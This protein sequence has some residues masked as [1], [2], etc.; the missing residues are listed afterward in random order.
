M[1]SRQRDLSTSD[2]LA[3]PTNSPTGPGEDDAMWARE[4]RS[5]AIKLAL[6]GYK[7][8]KDSRSGVIFLKGGLAISQ[9]TCLLVLLIL[10]RHRTSPTTPGISQSSVP[11]ESCGKP[12]EKWIIASIVRLAVCWS[13]SIWVVFRR[14]EEG[15]EE[16]EETVE[17]GRSG[18]GRPSIEVDGRQSSST[19]VL[20]T[21]YKDSQT[22]GGREGRSVGNAEGKTIY[23][24]GD[25]EDHRPQPERVVDEP[26]AISS[27]LARGMDRIAPKISLSLGLLSLALFIYGNILLFTSLDTCRRSAPLLWWAVMVVIGVGW[28][29]L[30]EVVLVVLIVGVVGPGILVLLR[31]FGLVA[32]LPQPALPFPLPPKPMDATLVQALSR[33]IYLPASPVAE[34]SQV[35]AS[36]PDDLVEKDGEPVKNGFIWQ[37]RK[38]RQTI[39]SRM[40]QPRVQP[41]RVEGYT[42]P[43]IRLQKNL[44]SCSICLVDFVEAVRTDEWAAGETEDE[45]ALRLLGCEH[46]FHVE[47]IDQWLTTASGRCPVCSA[48]V[49]LPDT[50]RQT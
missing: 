49:V 33:V 14:K 34:E 1:A 43:V 48:P 36:E 19:T 44:A 37:N 26:H 13:V 42:L 29:L 38:T 28:F 4:T 27:R 11:S 40:P 24:K 8:L 3:V 47:C 45:H 5:Q 25:K 20:P 21:L 32:P 2:H 23:G 50:K 39:Q 9:I 18:P 7:T 30:L 16:E 46:V 12:L 17:A 35:R 6:A 15:E 10:A 22:V 31:R 41:T